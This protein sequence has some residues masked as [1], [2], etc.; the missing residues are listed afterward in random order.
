M[1][2]I[3]QELERRLKTDEPLTQELV[4]ELTPQEAFKRYFTTDNGVSWLK[5]FN[6]ELDM[7]DQNDKD[8]YP[9][10]ITLVGPPLN[11]L[12]N[13]IGLK[14]NNFIPQGYK[15]NGA[16]IVKDLEELIKENPTEVRRAAVKNDVTPYLV[17]VLNFMVSHIN[18][19][20]DYKLGVEIT[21]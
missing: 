18:K 3:R 4:K 14:L 19:G 10:L 16:N 15:L 6:T 12:A 2:N 13:K 8:I 7:V 21:D 20:L 11:Y 1:K 9:Y 17:N 5:D